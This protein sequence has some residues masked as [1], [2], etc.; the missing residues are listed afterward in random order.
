M[1]KKILFALASIISLLLLVSTS[2][3]GLFESIDDEK[4]NNTGKAYIKVTFDTARMIYP[5][6]LTTDDMSNIKLIGL[7]YNYNAGETESKVLLSADTYSELTSK[8]IE[9]EPRWWGFTLT[10]TI[11]GVEFKDDMSYFSYVEVKSG[12][13][14]SLSFTNMAVD[15]SSI[16]GFG[17]GSF[18]LTLNIADGNATKAVG[19]LSQ[20]GDEDGTELAIENS[21]VV[22]AKSN[23]SSGTCTIRVLFYGGENRDVLLNTYME[24]VY[25]DSGHI[26]TAE[27]TISLNSMYSITYENTDGATLTEGSYAYSYSRHSEI[28]LPKLSKSGYAFAGWYK[29]SDC[30]GDAVETIAK[31]TTGDITLYALFVNAIY[32]SASGSESNNGYTASTPVPSI[33]VALEKINSLNNVGLAIISSLNTA[34]VDYTIYI[35]GEITGGQSITMAFADYAKSLTIEGLTGNETDILNGGFTA[36]NPGTTFSLSADI[37]V[38]IKNLTITGGYNY[39]GIVIDSG[40]VTLSEGVK[41]TDNNGY[42][43]YVTSSLTINGGTICN[44]TDS[45][46]M[47][48]GKCYMISGEISNNTTNGYGGGVYIQ[49]GTFSMSGGSITGNS[50]QAGGGGVFIEARPDPDIS[51][52]YMTG[53][54]IRGNSTSLYGGAVY[55]YNNGDNGNISIFDMSG[56]TISDNVA[57]RGMG[58]SLCGEPSEFKMSGNAYIASDNDVWL[59]INCITIA[60]TL[61]GTTPVAT[62]TPSSFNPDLTVLKVANDA[63]TTIEAEYSKFALSDSSYS[64]GADGT[65]QQN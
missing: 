50:A 19:Y 30:T 8:T 18:S 52:F 62:I 24:S 38:T 41:V 36:D 28:T 22:F 7:Y 13:T 61:T 42:G 1:N 59:A 54:S 27:R 53:G 2:C 39:S 49:R 58:V 3:S 5:S 63:E 45:G 31:G 14:I 56:G 12:E 40:N 35:D 34:D 17:T 44:N 29:T 55:V 46:V 10:A 37:S 4:S 32:V 23:L 43:A 51:T 15:Y 6:K 9:I 65:L 25:I 11:N 33:N 21:S 57:E 20:Y 47:V 60:G 48:Q 26:S 64:I 16:D